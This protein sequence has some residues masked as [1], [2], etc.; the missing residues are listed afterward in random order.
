M[1]SNPNPRKSGSDDAE[2]LREEIQR[3]RER[4]GVTVEELAGKADV[5]ARA[6]EKSAQV[7]AQAQNKAS[8]AR[9]LAQEKAA[10]AAWAVQQTAAQAAEKTHARSEQTRERL[11]EPVRSAAGQV[12]RTGRRTPP[13]VPPAVVAAVSGLVLLVCRWRAGDR[14]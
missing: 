11:A 3:T 6:Q 4:L 13:W 8:R 1:T 12:V 5:K 2:E 9:S 10:H 7:K 14:Q